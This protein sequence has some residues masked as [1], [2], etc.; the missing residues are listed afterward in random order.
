MADVTLDFFNDQGR[1]V[2][3]IRGALLSRNRNGNYYL[4]MPSRKYTDRQSGQ[5]RWFN[6]VQLFPDDPETVRKLTEVVIAKAKAAGVV[7]GQGQAVVPG[8]RTQQQ[9]QQQQ[10]PGGY[11]PPATPPAAPP[12]APAAAPE[13]PAPTP[14]DPTDLG[15]IFA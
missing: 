15:D 2:A 8:A 10:A 7:I 3:S 4:S 9:G 5:Q 13:A 14:E 1:K 12:A 6:Y 11:A